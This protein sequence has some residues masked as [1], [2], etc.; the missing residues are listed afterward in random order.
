MRNRWERIP[1]NAFHHRLRSVVRDHRS[2]NA[3]VNVGG[4]S[5]AFALPALSTSV[6]PKPADGFS[7]GATTSTV[8]PYAKYWT[9]WDSHSSHT[10]PRQAKR[11]RSAAERHSRRNS[12]MSIAKDEL[13]RG[14]PT[15]RGRQEM[16]VSPVILPVTED[17]AG[18]NGVLGDGKGS[19]LPARSFT[20][21]HQSLISRRP[22]IASD[23]GPPVAPL[24][25]PTPLSLDG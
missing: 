22:F 3:T 24:M 11:R 20:T 14:S 16:L 23:S 6:S 1:I 21:S 10:S 5:S 2:V 19:K 13:R 12:A 25:S 15:E 8:G 7:Y 17:G 4:P 18:G 9:V